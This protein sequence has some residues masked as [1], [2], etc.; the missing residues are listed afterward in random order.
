MGQS[1]ARLNQQQAAYES[2]DGPETR[3][4]IAEKMR[5]M[6]GGQEIKDQGQTHQGV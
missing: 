2:E 3:D 1:F 6:A 5:F 4:M